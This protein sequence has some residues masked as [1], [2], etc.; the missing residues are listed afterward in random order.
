MSVAEAFKA[1]ITSDQVFRDHG[2]F[3]DNQPMLDRKRGAMI[4]HLEDICGGEAERRSFLKY[5]FDVDSSA[6]L[7]CRHQN[8][9]YL[10]LAPQRV[11]PHDD[12]DKRWEVGNAKARATA[13]A[14]VAAA[15]RAAGQ[16]TLE[17]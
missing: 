4:A 13:A 8:A 17:I 6:D 14:V 9:L 10:W 16:L 15:L 2:T 11:N 7:H 12:N 3:V 5:V 1:W